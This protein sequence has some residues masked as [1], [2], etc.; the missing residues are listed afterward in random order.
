MSRMLPSHW[1][2]HVSQKHLDGIV[3]IS[4]A[5]ALPLRDMHCFMGDAS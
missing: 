3:E 4:G 2:S 1:E 5:R